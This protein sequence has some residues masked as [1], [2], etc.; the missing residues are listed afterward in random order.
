MGLFSGL[1]KFGLK[2]LDETEIYEKQKEVISP[3]VEIVTQEKKE[4]D[5]II[6]RRYTCPVCGLVFVTRSVKVSGV[7]ANDRDTDLRPIF[8]VFDALKYDAISC[9]KCG[10]SAINRYFKG[11]T[12]KQASLIKE[13]VGSNFK[14]LDNNLL[15]YSYDDAILRHKLALVCSIVK[16]AKNSEKA[17][18][19]LKYAWVLR[20]KRLS[21]DIRDAGNHDM[22]KELYVDEM[23]CL[24]NAYEGFEVAMSKENYPIAGMDE[25]TLKYFMADTARKLKKFDVAMRFTGDILTNKATPARIK[26]EALKEKELIKED[27]KKLQNKN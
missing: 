6:N 5:F 22:I 10:Y 7:R 12:S 13:N 20:G 4:E 26:D 23:D 16:K 27:M 11:V 25:I 8:D 24:K 2:N 17:Y 1:E 15:I 3:T 18:T 21:L 14:G 19:C 9:D